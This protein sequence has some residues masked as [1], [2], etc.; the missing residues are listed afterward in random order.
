[1]VLEFRKAG[2]G[3]TLPRC[4]KCRIFF[5]YVVGPAFCDH[6]IVHVRFLQFPVGTA[7]LN[8][9]RINL[10]T[11]PDGASSF[12]DPHHGPT[13]TGRD[14]TQTRFHFAPN[15]GRDAEEVSFNSFL[16]RP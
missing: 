14:E 10:V 7:Q 9:R 6:V 4:R 1:M 11:L 3:K 2:D 12:E 15:V 5:T 16:P 8:T 13:N